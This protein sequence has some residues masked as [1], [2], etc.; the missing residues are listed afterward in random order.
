MIEELA[1]EAA[2]GK[3]R[4]HIVKHAPKTDSELLDELLKKHKMT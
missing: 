1:R 2:E 4:L 3:T